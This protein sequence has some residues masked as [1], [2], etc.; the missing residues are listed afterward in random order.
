MEDEP[1][2]LQI[3]SHKQCLRRQI[4]QANILIVYFVQFIILKAGMCNLEKCEKKR[5]KTGQMVAIVVRETLVAFYDPNRVCGSL[6]MFVTSWLDF[7]DSELEKRYRGNDDD[8]SQKARHEIQ[9]RRS[10]SSRSRG[11]Q[12]EFRVTNS[13]CRVGLHASYIFAAWL[14]LREKLP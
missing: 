5:S 4:V 10:R 9:D 11:F 12:P 8:A 2:E 6:I 13:F 7:H 1:I 3:F 14:G